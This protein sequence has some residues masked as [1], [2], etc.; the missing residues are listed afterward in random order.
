MFY[1]D[2]KTFQKLTGK[3]APA[4]TRA[5]KRKDNPV[6]V[7][8]KDRSIFFDIDNPVVYEYIH[9]RSHK[10]DEKTRLAE[11]EAEAFR[12]DFDMKRKLGDYVCAFGG[13]ED[14]FMGAFDEPTEPKS[15]GGPGGLSN[16]DYKTEYLR[17]NVLKREEEIEK[18]KLA[19][20]EKK[21][22]S[23]DRKTVKGYLQK[24]L[25]ILHK[26]HLDLPATGLAGDVYAAARRLEG[27]EAEKEI[28]RLLGK[29]LAGLLKDAQDMIG[30]NPL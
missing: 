27:R 18:L 19:N 24:Y 15:M 25:G 5:T 6:P 14:D 8:K 2:G 21:G 23:I 9:T 16:D 26:N 28:E 7:R 13:A 29:A 17:L 22:S 1:V 12:I 30:A 3:S 4:V 10:N 20:L 11:K